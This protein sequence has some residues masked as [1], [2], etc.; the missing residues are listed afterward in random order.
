MELQVW[1]NAIEG[2]EAVAEIYFSFRFLS[3]THL[4]R[5]SMINDD[6]CLCHPHEED[7][8]VQAIKETL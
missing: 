4:E 1:L 8:D 6:D 7:Y 2:R 3:T 5:I